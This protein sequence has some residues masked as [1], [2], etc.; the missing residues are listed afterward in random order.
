M[1]YQHAFRRNPEGVRSQQSTSQP[2]QKTLRLGD[3][4]IEPLRVLLKVETWPR[5]H[6]SERSG[7]QKVG[8]F[9]RKNGAEKFVLY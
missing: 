4:E 6:D 9:V 2:F 1:L 3:R 8:G 5:L 7:N